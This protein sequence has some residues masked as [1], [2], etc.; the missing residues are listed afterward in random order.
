V[1]TG[2]HCPDAPRPLLT[3]PLCPISKSWEPC[4]PTKAPDDPQA[5]TLNILWFQKKGTQIRK[6]I[7]VN[8]GFTV[9][10]KKKM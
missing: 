10:V 9:W 7:R 6:I 1:G 4:S 5:H 2:P 3:G 8:I